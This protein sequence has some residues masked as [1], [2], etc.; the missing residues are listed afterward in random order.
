MDEHL[1][2]GAGGAGVS[3]ELFS[4][5]RSRIPLLEHGFASLDEA[6]R[7]GNDASVV[8]RGRAGGARYSCTQAVFYQAEWWV[9]RP[10]LVSKAALAYARERWAPHGD[11]IWNVRRVESAKRS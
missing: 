8:A 11:R 10:H 4:F 3:G 7:Q 9:E 1:G 2:A 6:E 5:V